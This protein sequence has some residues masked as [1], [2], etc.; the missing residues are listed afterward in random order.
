MEFHFYIQISIFKQQYN[1]LVKAKGLKYSCLKR[2]TM[3]E[4]LTHLFFASILLCVGCKETNQ[5]HQVLS[6]HTVVSRLP[7]EPDM[8]NPIL[9]SNGYGKQVTN[10]I[11]SYLIHYDYE[12]LKLT[13]MLAVELPKIENITE[14]KYAGDQ[15]STYEIHK[16][17]VWED[18][19]PVTAKDVEFTI[20]IIL[21]TKVLAGRLRA[22][23]GKIKSIQFDEN[24]PKKFTIITKGKYFLIHELFTNL[25]IFPE[26]HYDSYGLMKK[27][28][29]QNLLNH[30]TIS[31]SDEKVLQEFANNFHDPKLSREP[32]GVIGCGAYQ[33]K[34]WES[35][36]K[37]ILEK[38][39]NWWGNFLVK[40]TP[41]LQAKPKRIIFRILPDATTANTLLKSGEIDVMGA[42]PPILFEELKK[43]NFANKNL[44]FYSPSTMI[45]YYIAFNRRNPKLSDKKVRRALAHLLDI[46]KTIQVTYSGFA[47]RS[48]GPIFNQKSYFN[49][50]LAPIK[51]DLEKAKNLLNEAGWFDS[52]NNGI[53]DKIIEGELVEMKLDFLINPGTTGEAIGMMLKRSG[54]KVGVEF[55]IN[56]EI[57]SQKMKKIKHRDFDLSL[58]ATGF[59][60]SLDDLK[61]EWHTSSD[62][63][64]GGNRTGFGDEVSDNII[65]QLEITTDKNKQTKLYQE[66]QSIIYEDQPCIFLFSTQQTIAINKRLKGK[67]SAKRPGVFENLLEVIE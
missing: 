64:N 54:K 56:T 62:T 20:K 30:K 37:I 31:E 19:S 26:Y 42:I 23:F 22:F 51:L 36:Q 28:K 45:Y 21:N 35:G 8:L 44:N 43:N 55:E 17:A 4:K 52:N 60:Y 5:H 40:D 18:G 11:F 50:Q 1:K 66:F 53:V 6:K 9:S 33:L 7:A 67:V 47:E 16:T 39:E 25:P 59:N 3:R 41:L 65:E 46:E 24:N 58:L 14:G 2:L 49:K 63:P 32:G 27:F 12:T 38:K 57:L 48:I 13:P 15:A 61:Q 34:K 10:H 29:I